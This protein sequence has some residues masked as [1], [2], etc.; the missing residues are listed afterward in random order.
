MRL[1]SH[2][3]TATPPYATQC[4]ASDVPPTETEIEDAA[5]KGSIEQPGG[6]QNDSE[7]AFEAETDEMAKDQP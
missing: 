5:E 6:V 4:M 3:H 2:L 7:A 1:L